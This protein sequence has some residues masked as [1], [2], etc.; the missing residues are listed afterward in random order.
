MI[1]RFL[2]SAISAFALTGAATAQMSHEHA[3]TGCNEPTL[4]CATKATPAFAADGTLWLAWQAAGYVMV[5]SSGDGGKGFTPAVAV[6]REPLDLDWGPDARPKIAVDRNGQVHVAFAMFRDKAF[7]GEV[8]STISADGGRTFAPPRPVTADRESQR[9]EAIALDADGS[10]FAAWLDKRNRA[11]AKAR[12][13]D[14]V[15]AA[16]A[17]AWSR[18]GAADIGATRIAQDNTCECCRLGVAFAGPGRPVVAFRNAFDGMVRDHAIVT[19]ADPQTLGPIYR[20]S[21]DDWK[22]DVCPHHGPSLAI[23]A[24]G[25]YHVAWFTN[26]RVRQGLFYGRSDNGGQSFSEPMPVG[27][28]ARNSSHPDL[29]VAGG[30]LWLAWKEFD[31]EDTTVPIMVSHDDGLTW[32]TP[33]VAARTA[34]ASDTP[35]LVTNGRASFVSWLTKTEGYR[36]VALED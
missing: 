28:A 18:N 25:T 14:Y 27:D 15:G 7:N 1:H 36:L 24:A 29:A 35:L 8:F 4:A 11:P 23:S 33:K 21:I 26:G 2:L 5:A 17:F 6:N 32:S 16:L 22:T 3:A 19:F 12:N 9:F 20:I 13:Q 34:E 10:L 30:K 31:G